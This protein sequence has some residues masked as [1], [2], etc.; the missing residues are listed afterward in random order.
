MLKIRLSVSPIEDGDGNILGLSAIHRDITERMLAVKAIRESEEALQQ[1]VAELEEAQGKLEI[2]G[3]NLTFLAENLRKARDE[4]ERA[5]QAK[6]EFLATMSHEIRTPM[7]GV[8]GM[9]DLLLDTP[10]NEDQR[11]YGASVQSSA[12]ALLAIIDDILDF[13]KLDAGRLELEITEFDVL[14]VIEGVAELLRPRAIEQGLDLAVFVAPEVPKFLRGD[15]GRLRQIVLNLAGNAV[16]FTES[17][18]VAITASSSA[19]GD[20][21][22]V[23]RIEVTDTGIGIA[24]EAQAKLFHKFTQ[25]DSTTT[26]R[27]GGTG[28]GLAICKQ[29]VALMDGE[30]GVKSRPGKGS[31]F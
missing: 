25:A 21:A 27:Y 10:L 13:S 8:I 19:I 11:Q 4:A 31:T 3:A 9:A 5:N 7:N 6:S 12:L 16:K 28:L 23:L 24:E 22:A 15:P 14:D 17:G 18:S 29:L 26:R 30:I 2:Q 20:G 1:R